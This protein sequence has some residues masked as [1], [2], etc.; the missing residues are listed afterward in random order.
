MFKNLA[1]GGQTTAHGVRM[2]RQVIKIGFS[3]AFALG[4]LY[5]GTFLYQQPQE[6]YKA[7]YYLAKSKVCM[8]ENVLIRAESW[9]EITRPP[10]RKTKQKISAREAPDYGWASE[11][12]PAYKN[13]MLKIKKATA[14]KACEKRLQFFFG[15]A[16]EA[17]KT[18]G[19]ISFGTFVGKKSSEVVMSSNMSMILS[20]TDSQIFS[21]FALIVLLLYDPGSVSV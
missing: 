8:E 16:I 10:K 21:A 20:P 19:K 2:L 5:F 12:T 14:I 4:L 7:F 13:R 9:K 3:I 15:E 11:D 17:A 18:G 1:A 6:N